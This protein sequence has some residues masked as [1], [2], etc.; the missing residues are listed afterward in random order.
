MAFEQGIP[1]ILARDELKGE[2]GWDVVGGAEKDHD[3]DAPECGISNLAGAKEPPKLEQDGP[4]AINM[5]GA[6]GGFGQVTQL[7]KQW[8]TTYLLL[9]RSRP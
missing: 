7:N 9:P 1:R 4:L 3:M 6:G 2:D 5:V 8:V